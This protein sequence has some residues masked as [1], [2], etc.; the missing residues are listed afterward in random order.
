MTLPAE[1]LKRRRDPKQLPGQITRRPVFC[2]Y[3]RL[4]IAQLVAVWAVSASM[5]LASEDL[6]GPRALPTPE[7]VA[8]HDTEIGMF[9]HFAPNT[10]QDSEY[11]RRDTP[12]DKINP[13][14]LDTEQWVD[15]AESMGAKYIVFVAKHVGG[16]CMWQ[17]DTTDYGI[18]NTAWHG[19]KGDV[20]ADLSASCKARDMKLG[21][22]LS[23]RDDTFGAETSGK[24][25]TPE[26]QARYDALYRQQLTEVLSRYGEMFEVWFD[27]SNVIEVG[28]ILKTHAPKAMI[29]QGKY[30]TI[31]W[32]GNEDGL[33]PYP[34]WNC[35]TKEAAQRGATAAD[36]T[37]FGEVWLPS[38]CDVSLRRDWFWNSKNENTIKTLDQL[39]DIYYRSVGRGAV[40]LL[41]VTP[42]P[43]GLIPEADVKRAAEFGA[44]IR[45]RFESALASTAGDGDTLELGLTALR[46]ADHVILM[47]DITQGERVL[48]YVIEAQVNGAW[49]EIVTGSAI[50]HKKIDRFAPMEADRWRFRC[51]KSNGPVSISRFALYG[52]GQ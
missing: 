29:F 34:A 7:Q 49:K 48:D 11:D 26:L 15:V 14:K 19:G 3:P 27:G 41:N 30:A 37:P 43:T 46:P 33:A 5:A 38:E 20:L 21:V 52:V 39:M 9:I 12:L 1:N 25:A 23:P 4:L 35:T 44:E 24:C 17:T 2:G 18:K 13:D 31:R 6:S 10:W 51:L 28:D 32:V 45:K 16:F 50:G 22:Y 36:S 40:L 8:W 47:E 42:D